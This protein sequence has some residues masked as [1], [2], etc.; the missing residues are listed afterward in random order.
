MS[1]NAIRNNGPDAIALERFKLCELAEGLATY[2]SNNKRKLIN[3]LH[4]TPTQLGEKPWIGEK[5]GVYLPPGCTLKHGPDWLHSPPC[6]RHGVSSWDAC[7]YMHR[8]HGITVHSNLEATRAVTK[9]KATT[10]QRFRN[11]PEIAQQQPLMSDTCCFSYL[12]DKGEGWQ[13]LGVAIS[14]A[15]VREG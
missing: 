13:A 15:L 1:E 7:S 2:W 10:T 6:L 14:P 9:M 5:S 8:I 4:P 3:R 12:W 11:L